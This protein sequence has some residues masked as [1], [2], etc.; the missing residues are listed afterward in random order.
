M[1]TLESQLLLCDRLLFTIVAL[2]SVD[3]TVLH[4]VARR[5][6]YIVIAGKVTDD[7]LHFVLIA[8]WSDCDCLLDAVCST[9]KP[10]ILS[11]TTSKLLPRAHQQAAEQLQF[12]LLH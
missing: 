7:H 1:S 12:R 4:L 5:S 9:L 8:Q 3:R 2:R 6:A 10:V 11:F